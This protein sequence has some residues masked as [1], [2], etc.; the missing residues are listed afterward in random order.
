MDLPP[1]RVVSRHKWVTQGG[2]IGTDPELKFIEIPLSVT[3]PT[4]DN[5]AFDL[6]S[7]ELPPGVQ[8][9]RVPGSIKGVPVILEPLQD[10]L[11][12]CEVFELLVM[13]RKEANVG[14]LEG[15]RI[16]VIQKITS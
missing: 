9:E 14:I 6:I 10:L 12:D 1:T 8:I 7:C 2:D 5:I 16:D 15:K 3:N 11:E 4:N 13:N